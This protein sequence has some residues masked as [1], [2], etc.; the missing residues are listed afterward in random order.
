MYV[1]MNR[2]RVKS[3]QE[4]AFE[5]V[6]RNRDSH[7]E[8][9]PGFKSFDLL[10]GAPLDDGTTLYASHTIWESHQHFV[11]W[12]KSEHFRQAHKNAGNN[13]TLYDGPPSFEGFEKV[14]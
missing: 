6:W 8:Q 5:E 7:L 11:D 10:K 4:E 3:D 9:V 13:K 1:A 2:F 14:L 12:T